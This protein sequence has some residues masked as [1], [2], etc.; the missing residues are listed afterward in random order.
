M[1]DKQKNVMHRKSIV[2]QNYTF[3]ENLTFFNQSLLKEHNDAYPA[4]LQSQHYESDNRA[5]RPDDARK[6]FIYDIDEKE[7]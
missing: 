4:S 1:I 5:I 2:T 6:I 7:L 3:H